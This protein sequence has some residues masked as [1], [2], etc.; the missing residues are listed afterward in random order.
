MKEFALLHTA[1]LFVPGD[2]PERFAKALAA[3]PGGII[4]DL[5]DG[6][7]PSAKALARDHVKAFLKTGPERCL[8]RLNPVSSAEFI[9]DIKQLKGIRPYGLVLAKTESAQEVQ[10]VRDAWPDTPIF[11]LIETASALLQLVPIAR[12]EGVCQLVLGGLD[13]S[14]DSGIAFPNSFLLDYA[15]LRMVLASRLAGL[16]KPID[17]PHPAFRD[18]E[19]VRL[20][21][22]TAAGLGCG[23]KLCIHPAQVSVIGK[24]FSPSAAEIE[25]AKA[26]LA[27]MQQG[28]AVA[29]DGQ[30]VDAPVVARARQILELAGEMPDSSR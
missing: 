17:T 18:L 20:D 19:P 6:V 10:R 9:N 16:A 27:A 29:L 5:E 26:V 14:A 13:L 23:S 24:A 12:A 2:R 4:L 25:R 22:E 30:M 15:R 7:T 28:G 3:C 11:P 1:L 8:V 21:A